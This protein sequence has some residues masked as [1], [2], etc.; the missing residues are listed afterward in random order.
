MP[1]ASHAGPYFGRGIQRTA[2]RPREHALRGRAPSARPAST[3]RRRC[4]HATALRTSPSSKPVRRRRTR[5]WTSHIDVGRLASY[6][7]NLQHA[8]LG[9]QL[10][11]NELRHRDASRARWVV[12]VEDQLGVHNRACTSR[13]CGARIADVRSVAAERRRWRVP[14]R[15]VSYPMAVPARSSQ[16]NSPNTTGCCT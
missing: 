14:R 15:R 1:P 16:P 6:V 2:H 12:S 7:S 4:G 13:T 10:R 9:F 3:I 11:G 5:A 8:L